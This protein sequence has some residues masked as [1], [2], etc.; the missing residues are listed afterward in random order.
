MVV[1]DCTADS[2]N[3]SILDMYGVVFEH[4]L[5]G[6]EHQSAPLLDTLHLARRVLL[7]W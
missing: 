5:P 6:G 1:V 2:I 7:Q 3:V 4:L